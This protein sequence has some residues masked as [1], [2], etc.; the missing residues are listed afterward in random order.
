M[1]VPRK[2]SIHGK[3]LF[4]DSALRPRAKLGEFTG[5]H[6]ST[7]EARRRAKLR[8]RIA[9]VEVDETHAIDGR[10]GGGP[11]RFIN[12]SCT[13]NVFIRIAYGKV[14]F[15]ARTDIAAGDELTADYGYSHHEG[16][17]KCRC[18]SANCRGFL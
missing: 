10:V 15:Y 9:I 18:S 2:S 7:R 3:G 13:P 14:E 6:I 8:R 5:E 16:Q 12:H 17:L 11:F 1:L 4:T